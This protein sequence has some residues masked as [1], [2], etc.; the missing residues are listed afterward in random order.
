MAMARGAQSILG[1]KIMPPVNPCIQAGRITLTSS[2]VT[3][4]LGDIMG[5]APDR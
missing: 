3:E 5:D 1:W 4:N 2:S